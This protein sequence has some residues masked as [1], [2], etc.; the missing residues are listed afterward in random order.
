MNFKQVIVVRKDLKLAKGKLAAQA[1]HASLG[2]F[3]KTQKTSPI[4][5]KMWESEG[6]KKVIVYVADEKELFALKEKIPDDI[7][8]FV[9]RDAGLTQ[10][11]PGTVTCLG[12]GPAEDAK[13]DKYTK[14]L[15]LVS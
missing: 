13:I 9:V 14:D 15:K 7:A 5:A 1:S 11:E 2:A 12:I 3:Q 6:G 4:D 8:T 10:L